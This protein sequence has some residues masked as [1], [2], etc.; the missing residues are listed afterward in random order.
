LD[1]PVRHLAW[2]QVQH[3][4]IVLAVA[5]AEPIHSVAARKSADDP[6]SRARF[7]LE[8]EIT[9]NLEHP[10]IVPV[11]GLGSDGDGRPFYA[12]RFV[13][14]DNLKDAIERFHRDKA[15]LAVGERALWLRQLLGRFAD[16]FLRPTPSGGE[17]PWALARPFASTSPLFADPRGHCAWRTRSAAA[18]A[19]PFQAG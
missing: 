19:W 1:L 3:A 12:M 15:S 9:G 17:S 5:G 16:V 10:G 7:V 2:F 11:Y 18:S 14:G 8:A 4:R 13:R 6:Y